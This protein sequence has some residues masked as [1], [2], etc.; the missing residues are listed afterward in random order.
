MIL[1]VGGSIAFTPQEGSETAGFQ[2]VDARHRLAEIDPKP[3][4]VT[5]AVGSSLAD[6]TAIHPLDDSLI[7][8]HLAAPT[9]FHA[10]ANMV[11]DSTPDFYLENIKRLVAHGIQPY[12]ALMHVHGLELV[13][14]LIR[15]GY[16]KG[17]MNGFYSIG[18]GGI[19]VGQLSLT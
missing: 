18:G 14:R 15:R 3:D 7:G 19:C 9:M 4:Q 5:V 8:T 10:M 6:L 2:S 11:V 1:Q 12:F 17:P 16:Y 13:E